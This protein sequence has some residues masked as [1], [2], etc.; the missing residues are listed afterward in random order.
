VAALPRAALVCAA[1]AI[2][3]G[4]CWAAVTPTSWVPDEVSHV[5]YAQHIA[6]TGRLPSDPGDGA[7]DSPGPSDEQVF[8]SEGLPFWVEGRPSW[9][10][11]RDR[12]LKRELER[13]TLDRSRLGQGLAAGVHPPC[14]TSPRR[15]RTDSPRSGASSTA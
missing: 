4:V 1:I 10:P 8:L 13:G 12:Q 14:T 2:V 6:E 3:N 5:G 11:E 9:S 15:F 7:V